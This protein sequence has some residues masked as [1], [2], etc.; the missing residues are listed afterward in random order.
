LIQLFDSL[1][2]PPLKE[3]AKSYSQALKLNP[4]N[5]EAIEGLAHFYDAVDPKPSRAKRYAAMY[6]EKAGQ[7]LSGMNQILTEES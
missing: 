3:A 5:L 1:D 4:N 7:G 2:G 6:I